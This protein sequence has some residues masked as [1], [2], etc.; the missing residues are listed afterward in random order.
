MKSVMLGC[1]QLRLGQAHA[2]IAGG[3]ESM[4]RA[5]FLLP[6]V[7]SGKRFGHGEMLD[8]LYLDGLEDAYS[9]QLMG[10]FADAAAVKFGISR[11]DMDSF[12]L[13]S[14]QRA[15]NA[16]AEG[17]FI[18]EIA[19][20]SINHRGEK[21]LLTVDEAPLR[22]DPQRIP[23]IPPAFADNGLITAANASSMADGAAAL[24]LTTGANAKRWGWPPL[25]RILGYTCHSQQPAEFT[26]APV[27]AIC[28]LLRQLKWQVQTPDLYEINEAFAMVTLLA[29]NQL[30][31][32]GEKV[33]VNGGACALGHPLGAT[34]ARILV[35]LLY[36]LQQRGGGRGI[37][38]LCIGGGEAT[39]MAIET[40]C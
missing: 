35:T 13:R 33:N 11:T 10:S 16:I 28:K 36:A 3:M 21:Q 22:A 27:G 37:A 24:L 23:Q 39:A 29:I 38:S 31:I 7:R 5:P 25:A 32:D 2:V 40:L 6:N 26:Q 1:D 19:P 15:K 9:G 8:H 14:L 30:G 18:T 17:L 12:A 34:G 20:L 4:S